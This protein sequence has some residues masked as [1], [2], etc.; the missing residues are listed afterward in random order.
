MSCGGKAE[1]HRN[2]DAPFD[3]GLRRERPGRKRAN[4]KSDSRPRAMGAG[5]DYLNGKPVYKLDNAALVDH[6]RMC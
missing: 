2:T 3:H 1:A 5:M 4:P 6:V